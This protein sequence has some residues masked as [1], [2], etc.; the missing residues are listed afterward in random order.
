MLVKVCVQPEFLAYL[1]E[2]KRALSKEKRV[3]EQNAYVIQI[4]EIV[5]FEK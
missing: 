1:Q 5:I 2:I 4:L 3:F